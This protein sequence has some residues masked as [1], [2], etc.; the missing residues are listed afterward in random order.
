MILI[1]EE[2]KKLLTSVL[3]LTICFSL[4]RNF[5][6]TNNNFKFKKDENLLYDVTLLDKKGDYV[7]YT[8]NLNEE[9]ILPIYQNKESNVKNCAYATFQTATLYFGRSS[10]G[11]VFWKIRPSLST[12]LLSSGFTGSFSVVDYSGLSR[13][14]YMYSRSFGAYVSAPARCGVSLVG[15]YYVLGFKPLNIS[16]HVRIP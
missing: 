5:L 9:N 7:T 3:V 8:L 14:H 15:K 13:G 4:F 6:G 16:Y 10:N 2:M 12:I 11:K 1:G